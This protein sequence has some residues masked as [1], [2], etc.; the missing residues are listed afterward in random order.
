MALMQI[1]LE[2]ARDHD[3]PEGS[4]E[5]GYEFVAP[6]TGE[7]ELDPAGW[8]A[9]RKSCWVRRF[10]PGEDDANGR[11]VHHQG[12]LWA[13]HYDGAEA[14]PEEPI[15][16]FDRHRFSPGDYVSITEHD[17]ALRTFRVI[18]ARPLH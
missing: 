16:R 6:L 15:F 13:F 1:R 4:R 7:G 12:R 10:W 8:H 5:R 18:S 17:G 2:L 14:L 3:F 11:L 9:A